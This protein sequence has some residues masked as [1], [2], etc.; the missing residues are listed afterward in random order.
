[1][2]ILESILYGIISGFTE[3]LPISSVGHQRLLRIF[4]GVESPEPLRDIFV[5]LAC[6]TVVFLSCGT[7]I[8]K[9][10]REQILNSKAVVPNSATVKFTLI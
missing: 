5:H 2:N 1:M 8:E 4:Y 6:L 7:Y 10:R 3:F 9:L